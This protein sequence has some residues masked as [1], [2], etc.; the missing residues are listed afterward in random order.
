MP[1]R[2]SNKMNIDE[3]V[4]VAHHALQGFYRLRKITVY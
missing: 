3:E 1:D 4:V 2:D